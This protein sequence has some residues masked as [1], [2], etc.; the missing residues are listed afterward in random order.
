[1]THRITI[2]PTAQK[3]LEALPDPVLR[4]VDGAISAL[5][6]EPRPRGC[7]KVRGTSL[8][9]VRVGEYRV[10]YRVDDRARV[11]DVVSVG[12]RREVYR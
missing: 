10:L 3:E 12:H 1:M 8:Y 7:T 6:S 5:G 4:R 9:R 2:K 11:V